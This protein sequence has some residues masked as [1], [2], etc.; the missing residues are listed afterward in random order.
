[1]WPTLFR[2]CIDE[3]A[4]A[5]FE[6]LFVKSK[7]ISNFAFQYRGIEQLV[8]RR[9][10][11][12]EV[13]GSSPPPATKRR[14]N[15]TRVVLFVFIMPAIFPHAAATGAFPIQAW[16]YF[17]RLILC[18]AVFSNASLTNSTSVMRE[19]RLT[20]LF[21]KSMISCFS[22]SCSLLLRCSLSFSVS[23]SRRGLRAFL[24]AGLRETLRCRLFR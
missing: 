11:N 9:A 24:C 16:Q 19:K 14:D 23:L 20:C 4:F 5:G 13:G 10:H 8:A 2:A 17:I 7:I 18:V 21:T 6:K 12:P 3:G 1:M 15:L 22:L